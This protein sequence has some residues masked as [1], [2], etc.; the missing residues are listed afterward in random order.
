MLR[1]SFII[2]VLLLTAAC[3]TNPYSKD[4]H[5]QEPAFK[6]FD[7]FDGNVTAWAIV[8]NRRGQVVQRFRAD[9]TGSVDG[10]ELVLDETFSYSLGTGVSKRIW[11][12]KTVGENRYQGKANDI[13]AA[14]S[15]VIY[16]NALNWQ[17]PMDLNLDSGTYRVKF[18]DWMW[19][20]DEKTL[21]NRAYIRKFGIVMAEVSILM[22]KNH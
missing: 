8:Q 17:Y 2:I 1:H 7:F 5:S 15:G 19:M 11:T 10:D 3:G 6:L 16:G 9:I 12:I 20:I 14:A 18:D 21:M 22:R 4:Y 13:A